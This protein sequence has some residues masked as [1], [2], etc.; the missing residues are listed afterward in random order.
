MTDPAP[1]EWFKTEREARLY[2]VGLGYD[3]ST[4]KFNTDKNNGLMICDGK[5]ISKFSVLEYAQRQ[6]KSSSAPS[7]AVREDYI[8][9]REKADTE[10]A[11]ADARIAND[12]A[13]ESERQLDRKWMLRSEHEEQ[14]AAFAGLLEDTFRHRVYL[15]HSL[16]L[17]AAGGQSSKASEFANELQLF[18]RRSFGDISSYKELTV[19]FDTLEADDDDD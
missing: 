4:G 6:K 5:R 18:C 17:L 8:A 12:K 14:M 16:L 3:I 11:E 10:K 19:E 9:R 1:A 2:L 13:D 15:D 7:L